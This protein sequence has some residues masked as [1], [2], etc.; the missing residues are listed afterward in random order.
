MAKVKRTSSGKFSLE[1]SNVERQYIFSVLVNFL[2][3]ESTASTGVRIGTE[4]VVMRHLYYC[5]LNQL[6]IRK[7]FHTSLNGVK[8]ILIERAEAVAIMW[9]LRQ[10]DRQLQM[11]EIKSQLHKLLN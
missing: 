4:V 6:V 10:Y 2:D 5:V 9:L 8:R 11:L 7:H 3:S 1:L